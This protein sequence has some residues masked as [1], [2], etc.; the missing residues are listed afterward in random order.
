M[1]AN[2]ASTSVSP[3]ANGPLAA[4]ELRLHRRLLARRELPVRRPDLPA[5]QP[6]AAR[7]ARA[8]ARQAAAARPLGHDARAST[9]ST[10]TSTG[11][12]ASGTSTRSTSPGP[13]TAAR[14]S[15]PT[16]TSRAPTARSTRASRGTRTGM[17]RLFRQFSFPGGIPSHVAPGDAGLDPRGRRARLRA[18]AR[19]RRRVR[20]PG[21]ARLLRRRRRRGRDRPA[22][23]EL[24][25]EQVPRPGRATARCCRSCTS[26]ATRSPTRRCSRASPTTSCARCCEGYGY[27]PY[28]VDGRRP[29]RRCTSSMA[30]TLD[31]VVDEIAAIQRAARERRRHRAARAGR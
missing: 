4:D 9:S 1:P 27:E 25:L 15:S 22:G 6:A 21:P 31:E 30:A 28:F 18:R 29:G 10:R 11:S 24:A 12:S 5:R 8:R 3:A 7:A 17:R 26:T 16:P 13:A 19:L 20:Q 2:A 23:D 14:R